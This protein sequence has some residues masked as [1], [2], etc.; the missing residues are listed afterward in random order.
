M[1]ATYFYDT[2]VEWSERRRGNLRSDGLPEVQIA[3][4]PEFQG[5]AGTWT[6]EHLFV[7]SVNVCFMTIWPP[8]SSD[9][10]SS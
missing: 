1:N 5:D 7:G 2:E 10:A 8:W 3:A 6:P 9:D 4:P